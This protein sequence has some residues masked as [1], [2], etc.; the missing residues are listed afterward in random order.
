MKH[1]DRVSDSI[2][3]F[4]GSAFK[5]NVEVAEAFENFVKPFYMDEN[6]ENVRWKNL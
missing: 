6:A 4:K 1:S 2:S 5:N 3:F